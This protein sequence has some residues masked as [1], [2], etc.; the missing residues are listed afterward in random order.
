MSETQ[1]IGTLTFPRLAWTASWTPD[2]A[3]LLIRLGGDLIRVTAHGRWDTP[4]PKN[5]EPK[6]LPDQDPNES[7]Q[8]Y[9]FRALKYLRS[10]ASRHTPEYRQWLATRK[11]V[12]E[13]SNDLLA[14]LRQ[15]RDLPGRAWSFVNEQPSTLD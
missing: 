5:T 9:F 6:Q 1:N 2:P 13:S 12:G 10:P 15:G 11:W 7:G 3:T 8:T 4:P 14:A